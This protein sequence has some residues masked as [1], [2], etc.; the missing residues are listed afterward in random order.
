MALNYLI[1]LHLLEA[2]NGG[3][4]EVKWRMYKIALE[5]HQQKSQPTNCSHK[6]KDFM[7]FVW[8]HVRPVKPTQNFNSLP[9]FFKFF[10]HLFLL[11]RFMGMFVVVL[12]GALPL[13]G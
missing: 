3:G 5:Q 9:F 8:H 10:P 4:K 13:A 1:I 7:G 12:V 6:L 11:F 2:W